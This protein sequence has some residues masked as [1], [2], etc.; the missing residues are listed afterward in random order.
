[1]QE[2]FDNCS[3]LYAE[4]CASSPLA[5]H[6]DAA[7]CELPSHIPCASPSDNLSPPLPSPPLPSSPPPAQVRGFDISKNP[8]EFVKRLTVLFETF[9]S[10]C[11]AREVLP[12]CG[13]WQIGAS[14]AACEAPP[15]HV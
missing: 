5:G 6:G 12:P 8:S 1:M 15:G 2:R 14:G 10:L 7:C 13:V 11:P 4:V 3:V 9:D